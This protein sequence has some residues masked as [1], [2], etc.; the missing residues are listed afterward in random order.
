MLAPSCAARL[1]IAKPIPRL[2]PEMNMVFP[3][4]DMGLTLSGSPQPNVGGYRLGQADEVLR[5]HSDVP[6]ALPCTAQHPVPRQRRDVDDRRQCLA[7]AERRDTA[8]DVARGSLSRGGLGHGG[9]G[10][11]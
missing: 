10:H 2:A 1:A 7:L 5:R 6:A 4:S 9:L 8:D 3:E 11:A